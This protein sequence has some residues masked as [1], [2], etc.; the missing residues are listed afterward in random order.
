MARS[1]SQHDL[2]GT[3]LPP[4]GGGW[5]DGGGQPGATRRASLTGLLV[6]LTATTMIFAAFTS[7]FWVRRGLSNDWKPTTLP[8]IL[9][10]NTGVLLVSSVMLEMA[11][12]SLRSGK[13]AE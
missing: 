6:L 8:P 1:I 2:R 9:W 13:R 5:G 10:V 12:R 7:A 4:V 11:R 3:G